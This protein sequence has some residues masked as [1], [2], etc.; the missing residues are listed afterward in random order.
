MI[1]TPLS[2]VEWETERDEFDFHIR[3]EQD[4]YVIDV[5]DSPTGN[6]DEAYLTSHECDTWEQV[7][8]YCHEY[9]GVR[10]V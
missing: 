5:F 6:A 9:D 7:V 1:F 3:L 4:S 10:V 2:S 8:R